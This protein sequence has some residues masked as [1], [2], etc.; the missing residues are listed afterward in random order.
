MTDDPAEVLEEGAQIVE[1][2]NAALPVPMI[3]H[4]TSAYRSMALGR[5]IALALVKDGRTRVGQTLHVPM[6]GRSIRVTVTRPTFLDPEGKRVH[7]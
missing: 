1:N 6:P 5:S 3:G 2:P 7:G 4:V